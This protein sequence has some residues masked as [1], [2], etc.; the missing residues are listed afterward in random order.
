[1]KIEINKTYRAKFSN[2]LTKE[3]QI[4]EVE[5]FVSGL[6]GLEIKL[7]GYKKHIIASGF[8]NIFEPC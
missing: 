4:V 5:K 3:K 7:K 8:V 6:T 1:M 2:A